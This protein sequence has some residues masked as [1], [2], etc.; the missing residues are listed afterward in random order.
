MRLFAE[1]PLN[2]PK[3]RSA[4]AMTQLTQFSS[5]TYNGPFRVP[6]GSSRIEVM[7]VG[8]HRFVH[9]DMMR[10]LAALGVVVGHT[11]GFLIIGH[12]AVAPHSI[13][14]QLFYFV[15]GLGHQCVIAFF[16]LSGFLV[17]GP[18]LR[19][20]ITGRWHWGP[21]TLRRL[22]RLWTVLIPALLLTWILD[23][24]GGGL[25][26][27]AGYEGAFYSQSFSGPSPAEP[28]NLSLP[29]FFANTLFLQTIVAPVFGSN[30]PLWSLANEF[31]YYITFPFLLT[32]LIGA[33][34]VLGRLCNALIG[35]ALVMFLPVEMMLL[36]A[37]WI[38]GAIAHYA[39]SQQHRCRIIRHPAWGATVIMAVI[40]FLILDK[41]HPRLLWDLMLGAA[42]AGMLSILT[43]LPSLGETYQKVATAL[44]NVSYTL[45]ATH[46]PLLAFVWFVFLAP[47]KFPVG[48]LAIVLV[49]GL[50]ATA[51]VSSTVM[52]WA[53]ERNTNRIR[54]TIEQW[55]VS[56][57]RSSHLQWLSR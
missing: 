2:R 30:G 13:F 1:K 38:T 54:K 11:R 22:T 28:A 40:M 19:D 10:G 51:L 9:L 4:P 23:T 3:H 37:I 24:A 42:F 44:S 46:F 32:A 33:G 48:A 45:Y 17:G 27:H 35:I 8:G 31:W 50:G 26:G 25:G 49:T 15:T 6:N 21:Y 16:A 20:I 47:T 55:A 29:T 43:F 41:L 18:A 14:D 52:W 57:R 7:N 34:R 39:V 36:G 56:I 12:A 53:F 5:S